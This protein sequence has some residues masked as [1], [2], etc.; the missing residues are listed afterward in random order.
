MTSA[1]GRN[2]TVASMGWAGQTG[3]YFAAAIVTSK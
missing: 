3:G 2:V 1:E